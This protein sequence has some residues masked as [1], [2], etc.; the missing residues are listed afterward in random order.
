M[1]KHNENFNSE[2]TQLVFLGI[3][4]ALRIVLSRFTI[5]PTMIKVGLSFVADALLGYFFNPF[6]AGVGGGVSDLLTSA[7]FGQE[8]GFFP[9]FTLSAILAPVIYSCFFKS[10]QVKLWQIIVSTLLV[11]LIVNLGLNTLWLH[12]MYGLNFKAALLTRLAK[13][14]ITPWLQILVL[15]LLLNALARVK[16][17]KYLR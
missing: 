4:V 9:G 2:L 14:L 13:E 8:G 12:L 7:L 15:Y 10:R 1:K 11:T 16:I 17:N 3:I 5:G 6:W